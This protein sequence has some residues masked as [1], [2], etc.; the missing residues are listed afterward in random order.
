MEN[1]YINHIEEV[2]KAVD[3]ELKTM[4]GIN[5]KELTTRA[6]K[7]RILADVYYKAMLNI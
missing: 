5:N 1:E 4:F 7:Y 6:V 2:C 3:D